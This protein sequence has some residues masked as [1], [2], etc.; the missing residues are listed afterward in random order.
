MKY[1]TSIISFIDFNRILF[2][3]LSIS[4]SGITAIDKEQILQSHNEFRQSIANG[5]VNGQPGAE[6]MLEMVCSIVDFNRLI[7]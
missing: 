5:K 7:T 6:N 4:G 2:L 3:F 1:L